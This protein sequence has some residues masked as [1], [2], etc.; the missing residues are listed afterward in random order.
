MKGRYVLLAIIGL[1]IGLL[2]LDIS[3][4]KIGMDSV[5]WRLS[6]VGAI[7]L[8]IVTVVMLYRLNVKQSHER[9]RNSK[10]RE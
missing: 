7:I 6:G 3:E 4:S 10:H 1:S 5:K 8:T 2:F 9:R